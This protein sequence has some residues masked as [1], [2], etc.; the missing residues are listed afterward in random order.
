MIGK[1][2]VFY[3]HMKLYERRLSRKEYP[4]EFVVT[5]G[6]H[7]WYNWRDYFVLFCQK[8]FRPQP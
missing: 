1:K 6:G 8:V 3:P 5:P 4:H 2:D 7:E